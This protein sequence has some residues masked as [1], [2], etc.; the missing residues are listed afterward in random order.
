[1]RWKRIAWA[2]VIA[3]FLLFSAA[4]IEDQIG[5]KEG[6]HFDKFLMISAA[7]ILLTS[8]LAIRRKPK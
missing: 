4:H 1:M 3:F 5:A 6:F 8:W 7:L 2:T